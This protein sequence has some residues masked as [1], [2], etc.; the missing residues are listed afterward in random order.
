MLKIIIIVFLSNISIENLSY[1]ETVATNLVMPVQNGL[2]Y[3]KNKIKY[4]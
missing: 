2:T 3:I 4:R 1:I